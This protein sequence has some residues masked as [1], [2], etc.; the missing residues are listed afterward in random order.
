MREKLERLE[1]A[2]EKAM[3]AHKTI[4]RTDMNN[5]RQVIEI[6]TYSTTE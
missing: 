4:F 5:I 3:K 2:L 1:G 6:I